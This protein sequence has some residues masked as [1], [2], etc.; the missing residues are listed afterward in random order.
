V[1]YFALILGALLMATA[2]TAC[3]AGSD[4]N[5]DEA[6]SAKAAVKQKPCPRGP[7][8][9]MSKAERA[10]LPPLTIIPPSGSPPRHLRVTDLRNGDGPRVPEHDW[11][12]NREEVYIRY[13][14]A[15]YPDARAGR[16]EGPYQP[17]RVLLEGSGRG[18][19]MGLTGMQVGGRRELIVPPR[20]AYPRWRASWGYAPYVTIYVIDLLGMEPPP[21]RRVEYRHG[22]PC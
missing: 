3:G 2:L 11:V 16:L 13:V 4:G 6:G 22:R 17:S 1:K 8:L 20:L 19:A 5:L 9:V 18:F 10:K 14:Q 12:T 15:S 21:D 7:R